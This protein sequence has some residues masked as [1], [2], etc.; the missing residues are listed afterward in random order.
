MS[1]EIKNKINENI[2]MF[3][4]RWIED[5]VW[6]MKYESIDFVKGL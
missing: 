4:K 2:S 1:L 3:F 5:R 6:V